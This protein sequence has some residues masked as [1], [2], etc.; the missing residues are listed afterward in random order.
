MLA[1]HLISYSKRYIRI[2]IL[3]YILARREQGLHKM[4]LEFALAA[5]SQGELASRILFA[6]G[7]THPAL[8]SQPVSG[9]YL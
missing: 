7:Q 9:S 6:C 4:P 8:K 5:S 1:K 2:Y 3:A